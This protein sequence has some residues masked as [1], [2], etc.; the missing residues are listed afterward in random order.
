MDGTS[1]SLLEALA[2]GLPVVVSDLASNREWVHPGE[3]G[4]LGEAGNPAAFAA[5]ILEAAALDP[6]RLTA[7]GRANR[8]VAEA[9]ADWSENSRSLLEAYERLAGRSGT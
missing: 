7:I 4:W 5:A 3:N 2:S 9:R 1:V 8:S 6:G